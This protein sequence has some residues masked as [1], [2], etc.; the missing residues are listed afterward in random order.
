VSIR[1][2]YCHTSEF[3]VNTKQKQRHIVAN[4]LYGYKVDARLQW[5]T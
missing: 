4:G 5:Q 2:S 1:L 3:Y